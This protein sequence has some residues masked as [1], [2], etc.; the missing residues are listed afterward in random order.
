M[1]KKFTTTLLLA[2]AVVA[3]AVALPGGAGADNTTPPAA[4][5][6]QAPTQDPVA[7]AHFYEKTY[8]INVNLQDVTNGVYSSTLS[9]LLPSVPWPAQQ[10]IDYK[11]DTGTFDISSANAKCF[12]VSTKTQ[13]VPCTDIAKMV[14]D[15]ADG[16]VDASVL[17]Q[18]VDGGAAGMSFSAKKITVWVDASG[19]DVSPPADDGSPGGDTTPPPVPPKFY[20]KNIRLNVNLQDAFAGPVFDVALNDIP[21]SVPTAFRTYLEAVLDG[22]TFELD[23]SHATCF[24]VRRGVQNQVGCS[25]VATLLDQS[26]DGGIDATILARA[27][28]GDELSYAA[29]KITLFL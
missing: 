19:N 8:R 29:K 15:S 28:Q 11:V 20:A 17:V 10:W 2:L 6:T 25:T 12:V 5:G 13:T 27:V 7:P 4:T 1:S 9:S 22:S 23:A 21:S 3:I 18:A 14:D 16:G 24:V 26:A